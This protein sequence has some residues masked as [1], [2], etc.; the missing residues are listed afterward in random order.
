MGER[1]AV[2][3]AGHH[4]IGEHE[5]DA[6]ALDLAQ[7][8]LR[9]RNAADR[10]AELFEQA[11]ADRRDVRIVLD[12][13]HRAAA[14]GLGRLDVVGLRI[15]PLSRGSRIVTCGALAEFAFTLTVPPA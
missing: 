10:I 8:R 4:D 5:I 1:Q 11:D 2:H 3:L 12:Q 6:V 14:A 9:I 13:Q 7:R 15:S